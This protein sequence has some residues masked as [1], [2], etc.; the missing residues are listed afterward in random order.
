VTVVTRDAKKA[1]SHERQG[2][3]VAVVDV[4]DVAALR[5]VYAQ[6]R[7][8]FMLNPPAAPDTDI[9]AVER[10]SAQA[11]LAALDGSGLEKIVV[12]STYG[13]QP[14][15]HVADLSVLYELELGLAT[16]PIPAAILR[17]AYYLSNWD[18]AL[19]TAR[20]Q[21]V[22]PSFFPADFKLPMVAP[23]DIGEVAARLMTEPP[24]RG[25]FYVEGPEAYSP[26]D[27]A[28][29]FAEVLK[30]PVEVDVVP[31]E[32]WIQTFGT[33]GFSPSAAQSYANMTAV[34]VE[35]CERPK[36]PIR[37]ATSLPSYVRQ[38][39]SQSI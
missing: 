13:A 9:D 29:A 24:Q 6:G 4:L 20:D 35:R 10:T 2:A 32:Q 8:L 18:Y 11:L 14:G 22:V 19:E 16:Q 15:D 5:R 26:T 39:L 27:V 30:R 25:L 28:E 12:A 21:G 1:R 17:S 38:L 3:K 23:H 7:R 34:T 37:G 33:M 31:R 36:N